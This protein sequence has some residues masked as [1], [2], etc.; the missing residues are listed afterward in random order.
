MN[1]DRG[2]QLARG[3]AGL[4]IGG[5]NL[6]AGPE[7]ADGNGCARDE[8]DFRRC[9][10]AFPA[11]C[12]FGGSDC[13]G[14]EAGVFWGKAR[15]SPK[16]DPIQTLYVVGVLVTGSGENTASPPRLVGIPDLDTG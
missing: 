1:E 4:D 13:S 8:Q 6:L 9:G 3:L 10:E 7:L 2:N 12:S 14:G 11:A 16:F 15:S 5:E